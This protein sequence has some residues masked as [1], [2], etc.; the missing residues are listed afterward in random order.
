MTFA[1]MGIAATPAGMVK[2]P[3]LSAAQ[4]FDIVQHLVITASC[5]GAPWLTLDAPGWL[6]QRAHR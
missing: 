3:I 2:G 6:P 5:Q 1:D 4:G